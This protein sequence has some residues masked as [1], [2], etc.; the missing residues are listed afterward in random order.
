MDS[1]LPVFRTYTDGRSMVRLF[2]VLQFLSPISIY[3]MQMNDDSARPDSTGFLQRLEEMVRSGDRTWAKPIETV[4]LD[5]I[6]ELVRQGTLVFHEA[7][8]YTVVPGDS[9]G[10]GGE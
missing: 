1:H 8:W 10:T 2:L 5:R 9:S 7:E 6:L 3:F 4:D